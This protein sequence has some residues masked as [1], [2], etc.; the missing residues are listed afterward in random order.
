[1]LHLSHS[2]TCWLGECRIPSP[3]T[4]RTVRPKPAREGVGERMLHIRLDAELHRT[5]RLIVAAEDTTLQ[6]WV[7][8][9]LTAAARNVD[10]MQPSSAQDAS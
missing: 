3:R 4:G 2:Y 10:G 8:R 7:V 1:M 6:E 5:L 9:T